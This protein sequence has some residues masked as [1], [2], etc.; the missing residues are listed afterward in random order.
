MAQDLAAFIGEHWGA[1]AP[2]FAAAAL[3]LLNALFGLVVL[4]E[5]LPPERR[6]KFELWRANPVGSLRALGRFPMMF[7]LIGVGIL[8]QL[9]HDALPATWTYYT[10]LKFDW[11]SGDVA[12]SL[13]AVGALTAVSFGVLPRLVV[14][15]IGETNAVYVGLFCSAVGYAGYAFSGAP[16][17]LYT[18]MVVWSLGG[19]GGP[20]LNAIMSKQVPADE[21]GELHGSA[22]QR[23]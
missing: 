11:R 2:F 4:K 10:M 1:R 13:M 14:P 12:I 3:A 6:R 18:W 8:L 22:G 7:G 5:S 21:Q 15:R 16:W 20:A 19:V 23:G 9:A 17:M